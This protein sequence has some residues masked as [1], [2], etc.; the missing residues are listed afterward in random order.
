M[1]EIPETPTA[2]V[3]EQTAEENAPM[4]NGS[5]SCALEERFQQLAAQWKQESLFMSSSTAMA[6]LPSYQQ[7][8]ALGPPVIPLLLR[9]LERGPEH[10]FWALTVLTGASPVPEEQRGKTREMAQTWVQ[11]GREHGYRW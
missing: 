10:W 9:E 1:K 8:I 5:V 3:P 2:S 11:W 7:I 6:K 4:Q